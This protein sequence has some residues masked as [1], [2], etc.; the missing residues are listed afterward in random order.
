MQ[1]MAQEAR[2]PWLLG[3][4]GW[5]RSQ[6]LLKHRG[7]DGQGQNPPKSVRRQNGAAYNQDKQPQT[8]Q[9]SVMVT[10]LW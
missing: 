3:D 2:T 9:S 10:K 6:L 8:F 4:L 1:L 7:R 5:R